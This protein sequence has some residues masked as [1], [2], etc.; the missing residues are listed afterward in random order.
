M[1]TFYKDNSEIPFV[2]NKIDLEFLPSLLDEDIRPAAL[3]LQA[4]MEPRL[5]YLLLATSGSG[6]TSAITDLG[7]LIYIQYI[8]MQFRNS[9]TLELPTSDDSLVRKSN[10]EFARNQFMIEVLCRLLQ[11]YRLFQNHPHLTPFD[12]FIHQRNVGDEWVRKLRSELKNLSAESCIDLFGI[13]RNK[14][15][16]VLKDKKLVISIDEIEAA[17]HDGVGSYDYDYDRKNPAK[18]RGLLSPMIAGLT[19]LEEAGNF[20]VVLTGTA[21]PFDRKSSV[22]SSINTE[23]ALV[24]VK[25]IVNNFPLVTKKACVKF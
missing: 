12:Y 7:R 1:G 4:R 5:Y 2:G 14:L 6:K 17:A 16:P 22:R 18:N 25:D 15:E 10:Y 23:D 8:A 20:S 13:Y 11:L 24:V 3:D 9:L 21:S 19:E